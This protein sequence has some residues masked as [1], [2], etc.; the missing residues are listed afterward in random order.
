MIM[1]TSALVAVILGE[2]GA[3]GILD[4]IKAARVIGMGAPALAEVLLVLTRRLGGDPEPLVRA[5][6]AELG[7]ELIPFTDEHCRLAL[8]AFR[9]YGKGV[10]PAALNFGDC[11]TYAVAAVAG[12]PL[13][14]VGD[15]FSQTDLTPA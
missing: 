3:A 8:Q 14:F 2:P 12:E 7:V 15:D 4:K 11:L 5:L 6:L 10:H 9:L 13:L 1:D